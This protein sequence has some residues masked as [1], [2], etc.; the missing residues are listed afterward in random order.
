VLLNAPPVS[1][2]ASER[3][4][5]LVASL[6]FVLLTSVLVLVLMNTTTGERTQSS[7]VQTA[8]LAL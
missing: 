2:R 8:K 1:P 3:G 4:I 6:L 5:V 7:N